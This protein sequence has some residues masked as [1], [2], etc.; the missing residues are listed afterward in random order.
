[1]TKIRKAQS[2]TNGNNLRGIATL[3]ASGELFHACRV[4]FGALQYVSS[5]SSLFRCDGWTPRMQPGLCYYMRRWL[6]VMRSIARGVAVALYTLI[7]KGPVLI[8]DSVGTLAGVC[9]QSP[10][11]WGQVALP[12]HSYSW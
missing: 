12:G 8:A 9:I 11:R 1:M 4:V 2:L 6:R 10:P 3:Y 5:L 7:L